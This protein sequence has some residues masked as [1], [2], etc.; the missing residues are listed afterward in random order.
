MDKYLWLVGELL[1]LIVLTGVGD[2]CPFRIGG[3][4]AGSSVHLAN[5][6]TAC[7]ER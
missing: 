5:Q 4:L 2:M 7:N 3:H 6:T 1:N